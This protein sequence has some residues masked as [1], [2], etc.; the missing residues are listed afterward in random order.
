MKFTCNIV[1]MSKSICS[2]F[3]A[4]VFFWCVDS[5]WAVDGDPGPFVTNI[6]L[7]CCSTQPKKFQNI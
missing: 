1:L 3:L 7:V 2:V 5:V 4:E 6:Q